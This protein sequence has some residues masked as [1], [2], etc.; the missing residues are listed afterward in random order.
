MATVIEEKKIP[1]LTKTINEKG[2]ILFQLGNGLEVE[3]TRED[4]SD[5]NWTR[6]ALHG[7]SQ[8]L[9]DAC[10]NLSKDKEY[11]KAFS[12]LTELKGQLG[13]KEWSKAREG[14]SGNRQL[15]EDLIEA[16]AKLKKQ[17]LEIVRQ[18]VEVASP[19]TLKKWTGNK[20]V[21]AEIAEIKAKRLKKEAKGNQTID[22]ID[23]GL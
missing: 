10:A 13:Q 14:G 1:F 3:V 12:A 23:L 15:K 4:V 21:A 6:A 7:I 2:G 11:G 17:D 22:D 9:G 19:E 16:L 5:E 8:R 20:Q 18:V